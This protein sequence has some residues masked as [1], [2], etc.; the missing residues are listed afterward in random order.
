MRSIQGGR[1]SH[2]HAAWALLAL[3]AALIGALELRRPLPIDV[4]SL[5]SFASACF[6]LVVAAV[7]YGRVR[8]NE[9]FVVMSVS[10][11]QVLLFSC[12]GEILSYLLAR[13][14][15]AM[16]DSRFTAWDRGLGLDWLAFVRA[17]DQMPW[18]TVPLHWAYVSMIPQVIVVVLLLGFSG[19]LHQLRIFMVAA[20]LCGGGIIL[21]SPIFPSVS[22]YV[23]LGVTQSQFRTIDLGLSYSTAAELHALRAGAI[24][25]IVLP[26]MQGI[27]TFP[28]Y[29]AGL[30]AI[31]LWGFWKTEFRYA[32]WLGVPAAAA[33]IASAPVHGGH[34]FVDVLA[35]VAIAAFSVGFARRLI[36]WNA[37]TPFGFRPMPTSPAALAG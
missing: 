18:L 8:R 4:R 35:G 13:E 29:H 3:A 31:L 22:S 2:D 1:P 7:F 10:L 28:S 25:M 21:L 17:M 36:H 9:Q 12:L 37:A 16:W 5:S 23:H 34:Y 6:P 11:L 33:L 30:G 15:G 32:R 20:M 27:I 19:R 26:E 14:G 24:K